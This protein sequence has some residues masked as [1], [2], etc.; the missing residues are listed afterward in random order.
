MLKWNVSCRWGTYNTDN[1][2]VF[3]NFVSVGLADKGRR[4]QET[5]EGDEQEPEARLGTPPRRSHRGREYNRW[6]TEEWQLK[7]RRRKI[8]KEKW[9]KRR[10]NWPTKLLPG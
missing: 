9:G 1:T 8:E 10:E 3:L 5:E 2:A 4:E 7:G 6:G